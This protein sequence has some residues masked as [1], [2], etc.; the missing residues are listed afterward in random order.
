MHVE[1]AD[2]EAWVLNN[3]GCN[4]V[5]YSFLGSRLEKIDVVIKVK[6]VDVVQDA[7]N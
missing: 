6:L 2:I 3:M 7:L 5:P 4:Y 1:D